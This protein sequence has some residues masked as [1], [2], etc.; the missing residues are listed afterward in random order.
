[1]SFEKKI[2]IFFKREF[3]LMVSAPDSNSLLSYQHTNQFLVS[4]SDTILKIKIKHL[5]W[6]FR[7]ICLFRQFLKVLHPQYFCNTNTSKPKW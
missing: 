4:W 7:L 6:T 2:Y 1:M 5:I 3:Q